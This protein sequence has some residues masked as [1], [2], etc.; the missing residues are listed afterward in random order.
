MAVWGVYTGFT[1]SGVAA[2]RFTGTFWATEAVLT[3]LP[4]L[5]KP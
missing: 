1:C 3:L 5:Y 2:R 4:K